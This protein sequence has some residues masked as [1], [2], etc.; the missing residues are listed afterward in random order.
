MT[1]RRNGA[2]NG[3]ANGAP[4]RAPGATVPG[5]PPVVDSLYNRVTRRVRGARTLFGD[6]VKLVMRQLDQEH[7]SLLQL[8]YCL[9]VPTVTR[10]QHL[11]PQDA[12]YD[13]IINPRSI[14]FIAQLDGRGSEAEHLAANDVELAEKQLIGALVNWRP[15]RHYRPTTYGGMRLIASRAPDVKV[16]FVFIFYEELVMPDEEIGADD[17]A[18]LGD[19]TVHVSDPCCA[20]PPPE[21]ECVPTPSIYVTGGGCA[22]DDPCCWP[23]PCISPLEAARGGGANESDDV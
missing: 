5:G 16:S 21:P 18:V 7:W 6:N 17:V 11:R 10:P 14:T 23:E 19:I 4:P 1:T 22:V 3:T 20:C 8:P 13:S 15:E 12:D 2:A 9:V